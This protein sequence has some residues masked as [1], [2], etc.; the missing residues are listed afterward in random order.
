MY[1]AML[2]SKVIM[3]QHTKPCFFVVKSNAKLKRKFSLA[4]W[5]Y[6][7]NNPAQSVLAVFL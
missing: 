1:D 5:V 3:A 7:Q 4:V 6:T 2:K